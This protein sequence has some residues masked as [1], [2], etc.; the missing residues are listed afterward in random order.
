[1]K[2]RYQKNCLLIVLF[3]V[4][5]F[6]CFVACGEE[7]RQS[8]SLYSASLIDNG[9][10]NDEESITASEYS[11]EEIESTEPESS[12][13][14]EEYT[15]SS[16][17]IDNTQ[18]SETENDSS[19]S[20]GP[21]PHEH[22]YRSKVILEPNCVSEGITLYSCTGCIKNYIENP[23]PLG[24]ISEKD[25]AVEPT[26]QKTGLTEG[27]HCSRC[28]A[29]LVAQKTVSTVE[30]MYVDGSCKWCDLATLTFK[31]DKM[32]KFA[33]CTGFFGF[34]ARRV[35]IPDEYEGYPVK[36]IGENA[37]SGCYEM[38]SLEIGSNVETIEEGAFA[39]CHH[40]AEIYDRSKA[41]VT[42]QS[43]LD[44]G[45]LTAYTKKEDIHYAPFTSKLTIEND[46]VI[47]N[48][49][50]E[51]VL[52]TYR[53]SDIHVVI[54]EGVTKISA[55]AFISSILVQSVTVARSVTYIEML[56][57]YECKGLM[58]I[59]FLNPDGWQGTRRP[60][61]EESWVPFADGHLD[62]PQIA[63]HAFKERYLEWFFKRVD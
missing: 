40:L 3:L 18:S 25:E 27:S 19:E 53:G 31:V 36:V 33:T 24:H 12:A 29:I 61:D 10:S 63:C 23:A 52:L 48:G 51:R 60:Y 45:S 9:S 46:F 43:V 49:N 16:E 47:Y 38:Y 58:K 5:C 4:A 44:N 62:D 50:G 42:G 22:V 56:A 39:A 54:P 26:C 14:S 57:F 21:L 11:S 37:F 7:A 35:V 20:A 8:D 34:F 30:H 6:L 13:S 2:S 28:K 59:Y 15:E 32:N 55:Y 41:R 17:S 1:M